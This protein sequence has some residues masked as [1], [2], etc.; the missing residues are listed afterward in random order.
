MFPKWHRALALI[1]LL[2]TVLLIVLLVRVLATAHVNNNIMSLLPNDKIEGIPIGLTADF[3]KRLSKQMVWLISPDEESLAPL[4]FFLKKVAALPEVESTFTPIDEVKQQEWGQFF[5]K[6]RSALMDETTRARLEVSADVQTQW[7]LAQLYSPFAGVSTKELTNDP[8]LLIRSTQL[9]QKTGSNNFNLKDGWLTVADASGRVWYFLYAELSDNALALK[10]SHDN[11]EKFQA[12]Q[13]ELQRQW[14]NTLI[15][16]RSMLYYNDYASQQAQQD[17]INIGAVSIVGIIL[18]T[19]AFFRSIKPIL[20]ITL[21]A[22]IGVLWGIAFVLMVFG[23]IHVLTLVMSSTVICLTIDYA[24][25]YLTTRLLESEQID[26]LAIF[27]KLLPTLSLAVIASSIAYSLSIL[28]PFP[29]LRQLA[30]FA[31]V[32]LLTAFITVIIWFP[33][34]TKRFK[35]RTVNISF[36][37]TW[38]TLWHKNNYIRVGLPIVLLGMSIFG[39]SRLTIDDDIKQ[40]QALP[41]HLQAQDNKI[42]SLTKQNADQK[43]FVIYGETGEQALQSLQVLKPALAKLQKEQQISSYRL[44]PLPS[45]QHQKENIV[46]L[47][48]LTI[49]VV[50]KLKNEG[51]EHLSTE[52]ATDILTPE[53]WL[54]SVVSEGWRLLWFENKRGQTVILVPVAGVKEARP[55]LE[56]TKKIPNVYWMDKHSEYNAL[57]ATYRYYLSWLLVTALFV[58]SGLF[59]VR[60]GWRQGVRCIIPT[61]LSLLVGIAILGIIGIPLN[62]FSLLALALVLGVG[63]DYTL[64]FANAR[65]APPISFIA[66]CLAALITLLTFGLLALSHTQAIVDFGLVLST[67]IL[68]AFLLS[69]LA[70]VKD[71]VN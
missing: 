3:N 49:P 40:L 10:N 64:F 28:M 27:F 63:I 9:N 61:W 47:K 57:F 36:A 39:L 23:Q 22:L 7:I 35:T 18:L 46:L 21:A 19:L 53:M 50:E 13:H 33:Y 15:L 34:L 52:V 11:V 1:W 17:I 70:I 6:Y 37:T 12:I 26:P 42:A 59:L 8:L 31:V 44:L 65:T 54:S 29:G 62:L 32:G 69:P 14:P 48:N 16:Q 41:I 4:Q 55:L 20:L 25:F 5:Y 38:L 24:L 71:K 30:V 60:F 51:I 58:I 56:L 68:T 43:W 45:I 66:I 2:A 67:G